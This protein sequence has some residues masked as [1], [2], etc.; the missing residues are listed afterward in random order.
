ME[1]F[2]FWR[3]MRH[4][5]ESNFG[6]DWRNHVRDG[7]CWIVQHTIFNPYDG[8]GLDLR[9]LIHEQDFNVSADNWNV[10][11]QINLHTKTALSILSIT[12]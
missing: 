12:F 8:Q 7:K 9:C 11:Q 1:D 6:D 4:Y 10:V 5:M 3:E 2:E